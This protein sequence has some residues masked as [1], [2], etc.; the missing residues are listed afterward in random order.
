MEE[1][2][3]ALVEEGALV[4]NGAVRLTRSV[5]TLKIPPTVQAIL[6]SRI[7]RLPPAQKELLQ[8][9]SVLGRKVPLLLVQRVAGNQDHGLDSALRRLQAREFI[10]ERLRAAED[11]EFFFKHALTQ[12]VAYNEMLLERRKLL[13]EGAGSA[14]EVLYADTLDDHTVASEIAEEVYELVKHGVLD[15]KSPRTFLF[16]NAII[17]WTANNRD[18]FRG[19][20]VEAAAEHCR[21]EMGDGELKPEVVSRTARDFGPIWYY[22]Y[23]WWLDFQGEQDRGA[24]MR[25]LDPDEHCPGKRN[26]HKNR[27][28]GV[29]NG[30]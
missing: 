3:M 8:I 2:V 21:T 30:I 7:D 24:Y 17:F 5:D 11:V 16:D 29:S 9:L 19:T 15:E 18:F 23:F 13:H 28:G 12:E 27:A 25:H 26:T 10:Y 20:T 4:R 6:A 14:I 22:M 1:I